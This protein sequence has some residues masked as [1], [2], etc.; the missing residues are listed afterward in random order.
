MRKNLEDIE[1]TREKVEEAAN[2]RKIWGSGIARLH[3]SYFVQSIDY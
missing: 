1:M 3:D 2:D